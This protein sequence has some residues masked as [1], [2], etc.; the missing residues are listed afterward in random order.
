M[1][2]E[3]EIAGIRRLK[4]TW[5]DELCLPPLRWA[6]LWEALLAEAW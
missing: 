1:K 3:R 2:I 6:V 4:G 5:G